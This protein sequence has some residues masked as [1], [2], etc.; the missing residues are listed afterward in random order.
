[1]S[2]AERRLQEVSESL[3]D[4]LN[5][6]VFVGGGVTELLMTDPA[7]R[8]P[9]PTE[10]L[11]CIIEVATRVEYHEIESY[12]G[13][14]GYLN[15]AGTPPVICRWVK[16][17]LILDVMPT[18]AEILG[19]TNIWYRDAVAHPMP[20]ELP[21]GKSVNIIQP[22]YFLVVDRFKQMLT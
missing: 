19:F 20:H 14:A 5:R 9:R 21:N 4:I 10:D 7:G 16:G 13:K 17:A 8:K 2:E 6:L 22:A 3:P 11:D 12:L 15:D 1:M 18:L